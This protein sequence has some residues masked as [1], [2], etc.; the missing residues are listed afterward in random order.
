MSKTYTINVARTSIEK[1]GV[2]RR[3]G[4]PDKPWTLYRLEDWRWVGP[5]P[6][7]V[8]SNMPFKTFD[9]LAGEVEVIVEEFKDRDG[10]VQHYTVKKVRPTRPNTTPAPSSQPPADV[11]AELADLRDRVEALEQLTRG[12]AAK[13]RR[14]PA[15]ENVNV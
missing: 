14:I 7:F 9:A 5:M 6:A 4:Q 10:R 3:T 2:K 13:L 8:H 1:S 11:Q 12:M 15:P